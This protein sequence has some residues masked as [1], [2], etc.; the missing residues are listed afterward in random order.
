MYRLVPTPELLKLLNKLNLS[1]KAL[2]TLITLFHNDFLYRFYFLYRGPKYIAPRYQHIVD[3]RHPPL[4][5]KDVG[6][7]CNEPRG[8]DLPR[9][10]H[11]F[12][13]KD[14]TTQKIVISDEIL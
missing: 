4:V 13:K 11:R 2:P 10:R 6:V 5:T 14:W 1:T 8:E 7:G 3:L 12:T 9:T